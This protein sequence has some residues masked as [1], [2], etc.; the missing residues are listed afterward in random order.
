MRCPHCSD[1]L[2]GTIITV[3]AKFPKTTWI[4]KLSVLADQGVIGLDGRHWLRIRRETS[5]TYD[6][7][8]PSVWEVSVTCESVR[9][10]IAA[11]RR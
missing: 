7:N 5:N 1:G 9:D 11:Y 4:K 3:E 10:E 8:P 2:E 6:N